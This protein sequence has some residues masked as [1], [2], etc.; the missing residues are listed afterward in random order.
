MSDIFYVIKEV[1]TDAVVVDNMTPSISENVSSEVFSSLPVDG[2]QKK[3]LGGKLAR[4]I[5]CSNRQHILYALSY[6]KDYLSSGKTFKSEANVILTASEK[7]H[8]EI[9]KSRNKAE[10]QTKRLIHNLKSLSAKTQQE[11]YYLFLQNELMSSPK[12]SSRYMEREISRDPKNVAKAFINILK[13][14][15]AMNAEFSAF[16]KLNGEMVSLKRERHKV[17]KVLMNV[18]YLF[19]QEFSDKGVAA[20]V[21]RT[22]IDA[23]FDYDSI[24]VCIYH[25]VEN[26]AKYVK[27]GGVFYVHARAEGNFV[28]VT[29]EMDS[30]VIDEEEIDK[31][32]IPDYSGRLAKHLDLHGTG[33]GL[34]IAS[35]MAAL[36]GGEVYAINGRPS[37]KDLQ[38]ARNKFVLN[39]PCS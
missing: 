39:I 30:L 26:A 28:A 2:C 35:K 23:F 1:Y 29:F 13:H 8:E 6:D 20:E 24:H 5:R 32:F 37:K 21:D 33:L 15:A 12:Q 17:H 10:E 14:T 34:Y 31:I 27:Q 11:I 25:L 36:N 3:Q 4:I 18:F 9:Q 38:Y 19:F 22:E 16:Q 7:I